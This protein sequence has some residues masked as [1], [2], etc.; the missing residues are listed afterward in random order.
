M[1]RFAP[2]LALASLAFGPSLA[3]AQDMATVMISKMGDVSYYADAHQM[4]L[5]TFDNDVAGMSNCSGG[6]AEN[7]PPLLAEAGTALPDGFSLIEREDGTMQVAHDGLPLYLW[8][9]DTAPGDM[10]GDG[11]G[12]V[13]HL[14][15]VE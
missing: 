5:Y 8:K 15:T 3:S 13:W 7:W 10:T 6:C 2:V 1:T 4:T 11:V 14:A 9:N 12:G